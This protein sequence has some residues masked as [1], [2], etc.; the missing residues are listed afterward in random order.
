VFRQAQ[1]ERKM[2]TDLKTRPVRPE[3]FDYAQDRLDE[4]ERGVFP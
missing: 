2:I 3:P 4:G 1:H